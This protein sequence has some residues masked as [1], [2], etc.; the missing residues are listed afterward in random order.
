MERKSPI[1]L[2]AGNDVSA[3]RLVKLS[4]GK[5]IH[6]PATATSEPLGIADYAVKTGDTGIVKLLSESSTLEMVASGAIGEGEKVYAAANGEIQALPGAAGNY[7][8]I[9]I[10]MEE[11]V[12]DGD[13]IEVLPYNYHAIETV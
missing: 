12:A 2:V 7:R 5:M 1:T 8:R 11:A 9:G 3:K 10:A 6:N 13:I 4:S